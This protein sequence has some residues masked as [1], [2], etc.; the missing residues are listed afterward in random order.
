M[1]E[2]AKMVAKSTIFPCYGVSCRN[3]NSDPTFGIGEGIEGMNKFFPEEIDNAEQFVR[4]SSV[5]NTATNYYS[6][7]LK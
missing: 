3:Q 7:I 5:D 2:Q 4:D 1:S 6:N